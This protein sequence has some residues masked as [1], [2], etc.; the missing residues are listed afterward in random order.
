LRILSLKCDFNLIYFEMLSLNAS[1]EHIVKPFEKDV[2]IRRFVEIPVSNTGVSP[3][4]TTLTPWKTLIKSCVETV[5]GMIR[6]E[7]ECFLM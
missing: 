5:R 4:L 6:F 7:R 3:T 2:E 1:A